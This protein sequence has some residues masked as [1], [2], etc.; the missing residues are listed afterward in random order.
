M[1]PEQPALGCLPD[2]LAEDASIEAASWWRMSVE[3]QTDKKQ[4]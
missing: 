4:E 3:S 1:Q 2:I